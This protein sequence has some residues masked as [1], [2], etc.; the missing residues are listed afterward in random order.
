MCANELIILKLRGRTYVCD[1]LGH[2]SVCNYRLRGRTCV[3]K[4]IDY[5]EV[6]GSFLCVLVLKKKLVPCERTLPSFGV[7]FFVCVVLALKCTENIS[8]INT[9]FLVMFSF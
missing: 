7:V 2:T 8:T 6:E 3:C 9:R 1:H 5:L 4:C